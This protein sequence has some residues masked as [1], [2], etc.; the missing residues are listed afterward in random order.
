MSKAK[1]KKWHKEVKGLT[2]QF[3]A[4]EISGFEFDWRFRELSD[5]YQ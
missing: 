5:K 3:E 1:D 2:K 4:G